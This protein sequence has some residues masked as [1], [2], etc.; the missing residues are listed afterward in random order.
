M[1]VSGAPGRTPSAV[2]SP[3]SSRPRSIAWGSALSVSE[4]AAIKSAGFEPVGQVLGASVHNVGYGAG[5]RCPTYGS[6]GD[7]SVRSLVGE[8]PGRTAFTQVSSSGRSSA[9]ALLVGTLYQARRTAIA[10][11]AADCQALGGH[12]VVGVTLTVRPFPA[13]GIEFSAIGTAVRVAGGPNL[14]LPFTCDLHG[15]QFA[16]L[17]RSG[18]IPVSVVLGIS[19]GVRHEAGLAMKMSRRY[20]GNVEIRGFTELVNRTRQDARNE[21]MLDVSRTC[22]E[23][24]VVERSELR[25]GEQKCA[26]L[27]DAQDHLAE[28]TMI[29]T[30]IVQFEAGRRPAHSPLAVLRLDVERRTA[31][32]NVFTTQPGAEEQR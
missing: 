17:I 13:G 16:M 25:V 8:G 21:L 1:N 7:G 4:F 5:A 19:I 23:G 3:A 24:V 12:G 6:R 26:G 15:Q 14:R 2:A 11:M 31:M 28:V 27:H 30:S 10:R 32:T 20:A 29:G 22:A 18:W 9:Y